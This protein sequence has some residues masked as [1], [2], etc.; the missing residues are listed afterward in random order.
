MSVVSDEPAG[1]VLRITIDRPERRNALHAGA[2]ADLHAALD[3]VEADRDSRVLILTGSGGAFCTGLDL[4][5]GYPQIPT[6]AEGR[7][8][9]MTVVSRLVCRLANLDQVVLAAIDG[10]AYGGGFALALGADLRLASERA[11][12]CLPQARF[13]LVASE[14]GVGYL[15]PRIVGVTR[16]AD[17]TL[18]GRVVGADEA[19][20]TGLVTT[21]VSAE[22]LPKAVLQLAT[23]LAASPRA[24]LAATKQL[25]RSGLDAGSLEQ[26]LV[27]EARA[28]ALAF[29]NPEVGP[30]IERFLA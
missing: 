5:D 12:F 20:R 1:G 23:Q 30:S 7:L 18:T 3:K 8:E 13:G 27:A 21:L 6:S 24:S 16:A 17:I 26:V 9:W 11:A 19:A 10:P 14:M 15:L 22:E 28:Q 4:R 29:S 25:L 2:I